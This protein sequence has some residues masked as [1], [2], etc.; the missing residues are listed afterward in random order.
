MRERT[1]VDQDPS[2]GLEQ[3][4]CLAYEPAFAQDAKWT[5]LAALAQL[6]KPGRRLG[7]PAPVH[8]T[9]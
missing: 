2:T 7:L 5:V 3:P 4:G 1:P 6:G 9:G 8:A